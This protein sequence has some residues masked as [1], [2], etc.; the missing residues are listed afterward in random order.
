MALGPD[1]T[2][3]GATR[4]YVK[5]QPVGQ[6]I[7]GN[8]VVT[9]EVSDA[10]SLQSMYGLQSLNGVIL[11]SKV[12]IVAAKGSA[13]VCIVTITVQDNGGQPIVNTPYDFDVILSDSPY[14]VGVTATAPSASAVVTTGANLNS[15]AANKA[16]YVQC[17]AAGLVVLTITDTAKTPYVVMAQAPNGV[18]T[19]LA[20]AG[21]NYGP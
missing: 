4:I 6:T 14:G 3:S 11:P 20:L 13:N 16:F 19:V 18:P 12:S 1:P 10:G 15:Y 17:N 5:Q 8:T 21:G 7:N 9:E 2:Y